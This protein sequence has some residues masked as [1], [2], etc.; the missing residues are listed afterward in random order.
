[1]IDRDLAGGRA[2][3]PTWY[4][5]MPDGRV[6][7]E[8]CPRGCTMREG[9]RGFCFVRGVHQGRVVLT[10][11][12]RASG[13]AVDPIEKKPLHHVL[14]GTQVFSFGTAGCNLG[15]RFCQNHSIS[16]AR[17][18][19]TLSASATPQG[20]AQL[21]LRA[22]C[23]SVAFTYND[24]VIFAEYAIDCAEACREAGLLPVVV[25]AGYICAEPRQAFF[26]PM[27]AANVDL[28]AFTEDFYRKLTFSELGP[29]LD[30]LRYLV[31]ETDVWVEIT[32]L[33]I[34]G[35][36]D[37]PA[38]VERLVGFIAD[39]LGTEIP[40]HFSAF[41]PDYKMMDLQTTPATTLQRARRQAQEAGLRYVYTGNI[42]D[43]AGQSTL[44]PH[45]GAVAIGRDRFRVTSL[46]VDETGR[47]EACGGRIAGRFGAVDTPD[48]AD[49][50]DTMDAVDTGDAG[51]AR[52]A[53]TR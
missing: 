24:P 4:R 29:V 39:E 47:C 42:S 5:P 45:C 23:R 16:K 2:S 52:E 30:T 18:V 25:T 21:A 28:K 12:G 6:R 19:E 31:H 13:F 41:H 10:S 43:P 49:T 15:C 1:M 17:L 8:L 46:S 22:G 34:P 40:L 36:N 9:Q 33:L 48:A 53:A 50:M 32:T 20:V 35:Q 3:P 37:T 11:Y 14:P 7:C 51:R 26:A 44:C 38:E 27:S